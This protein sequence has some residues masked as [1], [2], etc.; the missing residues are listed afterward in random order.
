MK[1]HISS[2]FSNQKKCCL[3]MFILIIIAEILLQIDNKIIQT[4]GICM[5]PFI[6]LS[7]VIL[8]KNDQR[9]KLN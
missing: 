6:I 1:K 7:G 2:F 9:K 8:L 5:L 4:F 3:L